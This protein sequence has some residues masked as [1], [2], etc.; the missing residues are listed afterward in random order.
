MRER[1]MQERP[2][3]ARP[4]QER[5]MRARPILA[6]LTLAQPT[7]DQPTLVLA[8]APDGRPRCPRSSYARLQGV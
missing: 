4:M 1:L 3:L 7:R 6:Q 8:G 2:I 5:L